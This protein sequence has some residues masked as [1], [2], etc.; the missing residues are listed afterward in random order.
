LIEEKITEE[1]I[2][3]EVVIKTIR[4]KH[5]IIVKRKDI[6]LENVKPNKLKD[7]QEDKIIMETEITVKPLVT[8]VTKLVTWLE[9]VNNQNKKE[10]TR[11]I[12][13]IEMIDKV[14][15]DKVDIDKVVI[16]NIKEETIIMITKDKEITNVSIVIKLVT[17]LEIVNN[18]KVEKEDKV[19]TEVTTIEVVITIETIDKI[20]VIDKKEKIDPLEILL[21]LPVTIVKV[22]VTWLTA[23]LK[24]DKKENKQLNLV[25]IVTKKVISQEIVPLSELVKLVILH[26][27]ALTSLSKPL[28]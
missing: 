27:F 28:P 15:I 11:V 3:E 26:L 10:N 13:M 25:T 23:V 9:N 8:I 16:D 17:L 24:K 14:E 12:I 19:V 18:N 22:K 6:W 5:V 21:M 7:P 1:T 2:T 20:E 4:L